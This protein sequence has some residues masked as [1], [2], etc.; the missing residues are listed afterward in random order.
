MY[1]HENRQQ[2][3]IRNLSISDLPIP[4]SQQFQ[5]SSS[6]AYGMTN[7][8][9]DNGDSLMDTQAGFQPQGMF[10]SAIPPP[11]AY[12]SIAEKIQ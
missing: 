9:F 3:Y 4:I 11:P 1:Q 5:P 10:A 6:A 8:A 7:P 12:E 2:H